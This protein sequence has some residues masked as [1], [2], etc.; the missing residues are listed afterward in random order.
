MAT[1]WPSFHGV[2][3][4]HVRLII[5][6]RQEPE[7]ELGALA[8]GLENP[9]N[10][11]T[12]NYVYIASM[13]EFLLSR[14]VSVSGVFLYRFPTYHLVSVNTNNLFPTIAALYQGFVTPA[15]TSQI[16]LIEPDHQLD[17]LAPQVRIGTGFSLTRGNSLHPSYLGL[18]NVAAATRDNADG[19]GT[20]VAIIDTGLEP[21]NVVAS[22]VDVTQAGTPAQADNDGHGTAMVEIIRSVASGAELHAIRVTDC[23]SVFVWDLLAGVTAAVYDKDAHIVSLSV[24]CKDLNSPCGICGGRRRS[25]V[26]ERFFEQIDQNKNSGHDPIIVAATGNDGNNAAFDWPARFPHVLAVGSLNL[27]KSPSRFSNMATTKSQLAYC[28]CPGGEVDSA[29]N[30]TEYVGEGVD[31]NLP[32]NANQTHCLG[33]SPATAYAAGVLALRRHYAER[34]GLATDSATLLD[35]ADRKAKKDVLPKYSSADHG[36]G[37]LIYDP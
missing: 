20:R 34:N 16:E 22:Y 9:T 3:D 24:G 19:T 21:G 29:G 10:Q 31:S 18:L 23:S 32:A 17:V 15:G 14:G 5:Q 30:T 28:M 25:T 8:R 2:S 4:G 6:G 12:M 36:M 26:C 11:A 1:N 37:R 13:R 33:T 35:T 27:A 7:G